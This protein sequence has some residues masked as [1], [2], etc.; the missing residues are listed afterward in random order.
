[1]STNFDNI[2]L[3]GQIQRIAEAHGV[4]AAAHVADDAGV[5]FKQAHAILLPY[6]ARGRTSVPA[7]KVQLL[8]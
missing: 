7:V 1:M 2:V 4:Q 6:C 5:P 8:H 3:M